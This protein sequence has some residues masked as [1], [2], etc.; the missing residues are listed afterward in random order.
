MN[1]R[2]LYSILEE[3]L[4]ASFEADRSPLQVVTTDPKWDAKLPT[5]SFAPLIWHIYCLRGEPEKRHS[6]KIFDVKKYFETTR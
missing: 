3:A 4:A 6:L 2:M 1:P 5:K